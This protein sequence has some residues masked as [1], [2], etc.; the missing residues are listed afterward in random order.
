MILPRHAHGAMYWP[1]AEL[2]LP[3]PDASPD[4]RS[5]LADA[6]SSL[7]P[8]SSDHRRRLSNQRP[9]RVRRHGYRLCRRAGPPAADRRAQG[10]PS[11]IRV[12]R[13]ALAMRIKVLGD[14]H[15]DVQLSRTNLGHVL[16]D[17]G[18]YDEAESLFAA[19]LRSRRAVLGPK[20]GAVASS[21][22]DTATRDI[23]GEQRCCGDGL[24]SRR[25]CPAARPARRGGQYSSRRV[26]DAPA[27]LRDHEHQSRSLAC[28]AGDASRADARHGRGRALS[29]R[30]GRSDAPGPT[31][32]RYEFAQAPNVACDDPVHGRE[33]RRRT[34]DVARCACG[35]SLR[36]DRSSGRFGGSRQR[37]F[38]ERAEVGHHR[39]WTSSRHR[40]S[41]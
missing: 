1:A 33:N 18:R 34:E 23:G 20:H 9:P 41:W 35:L 21:T 36:G 12:P 39:S 26:G 30:A 22:D 31:G 29:A 40:P 14:Q 5:S 13:L 38:R 37:V 8:P 27:S 24:S 16:V 6:F 25:G 17:M 10:H 19:A 15:S 3:M 11:G 4:P 7:A 32:Q 28:R 2:E